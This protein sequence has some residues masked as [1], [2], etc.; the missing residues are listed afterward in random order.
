MR[1]AAMALLLL[2]AS[3]CSS[4]ESRSAAPTFTTLA[5]PA[6]ETTTTTTVT[7]TS[8][9]TGSAPVAPATDADLRD[10]AGLIAAAG[11]TGLTIHRPDGEVVA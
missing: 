10:V 1:L 7:V 8:S 5:R 9:T 2:G 3:G 11:R 4:V 6:P